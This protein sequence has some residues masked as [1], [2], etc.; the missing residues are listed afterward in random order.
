MKMRISEKELKKNFKN[1]YCVGYC[2]LKMLEYLEPEYYT[3]GVYGWNADVYKIGN[4]TLIVTGYRTF[5]KQVSKEVVNIYNKLYQELKEKY[6]YYGNYKEKLNTLLSCLL[7]AI[8]EYE[9][10]QIPKQATFK[11]DNNICKCYLYKS[12]FTNNVCALIEMDYNKQQAST[13]FNY[14]LLDKKYFNFE[15]ENVLTSRQKNILEKKILKMWG[16]VVNEN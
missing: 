8:K 5:G 13:Q 4:N 16:D 1:I 9:Q 3:A 7:V 11:I 15:N 6:H 14:H 12:R 10:K 2:E